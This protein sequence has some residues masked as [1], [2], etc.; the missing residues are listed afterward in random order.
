M[1]GFPSIRT[2]RQATA[3]AFAVVVC[4]CSKLTEPFSSKVASVAV[5]Q[6]AAQLAQAG[7]SLRTPIVLRLVDING[8]GVAKQPIT[9]VVSL[10]G[11][12]V[13]PATAL[14]DSLGEVK[15]NWTLG[16]AS[17]AQSLSASTA[18]L[19]PVLVNATALFPTTMVVAQ[20]TLQSAKVAT[21]LKNDIVIRVLGDNAVPMINVTVSFRVTSG[22]GAI[23]PQS[24]VTNALGEVNAKWT[25][26]AVAGANSVVAESGTLPSV[27]IS[28][29]ATP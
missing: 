7:R 13:D 20:G 1:P 29:T 16:T 27:P 19:E 8:K 24:G 6:G 23:T 15:L 26:G 21:A 22:G 14:S 17:A 5:V 18:G 12:T 4:G 10:G 2:C 25:M 11:G 9:L 28:A 3:L